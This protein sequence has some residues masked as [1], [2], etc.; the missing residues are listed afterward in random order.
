MLLRFGLTMALIGAVMGAPGAPAM[1]ADAQPSPSLP[2]HVPVTD[3][4]ASGAPRTLDTPRDFPVLH[5]KE[6]WEARRAAIRRQLLV[7]FGLY[8]LPPKPVLHA[9]VFGRIER[10]GYTIEKAYFQTYP[11]FYLAGNLYRPRAGAN[12]SSD[13]DKNLRKP[14]VLIAHGHWQE[15]RMA[16]QPDGSIPARA[17]TFARQ[18]YVAFTYDMVG[19]NDTRQFDHKFAGDRRHWLWSISLMGLQTW[20]SMCAVDFLLSLPD[21]DKSRISITGESGGGTQT[22]M[23]GALDDR[24]AAVGP[25]VMVSHT[26]QGGC[27]CENAPGL[28]IDYSNMEIAAAA[29]PKPQIMVG[30]SGDWTRTM[31]TVEGPS[32]ASV[33]KL[34]NAEDNLKYVRFDYGHNINQTSREAVYAFFGKTLL[35]ETDEAKLK[36]PAYKMEPVEALRVFPDGAPLPTDAKSADAFTED[37]IAQ[38]RADLEKRKPTDRRSLAEFKK[39][40]RS[41]WEHTLAIDIPAKDQLMAATFLPEAVEGGTRTRMLL[42]RAGRGDSIPAILFL[43]EVASA[44]DRAQAIVLVHP[45]G[46]SHWLDEGRNP[47]PVVAALLKRGRAVFLPDAFLTGERADPDVEKARKPFDN[48]FAT[49]NR[50]DLQERV[51]DLITACDYLRSRR[52][53]RSVSL[54]GAGKAGLWTLL[55]APEADAVAADC[56]QFDLTNDAG[57]LADDLFVP[58]LRRMG[59]FATSVVLAAPHPALLFNTGSSF[60]AT[61]RIADA[62]KNIDAVQALSISRGDMEIADVTEWVIEHGK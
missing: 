5:T 13:R 10:D 29:A 32:V 25:C 21:V 8:P 48:Y 27:L 51:Q 52:E 20:N 56:T 59:D 23:L 57:L 45:E 37:R 33:Y 24:L 62:Y 30:A 17:I 47:G 61:D 54:V 6:E 1:P 12:A 55:A 11:G 46:K 18:G 40:F 19:F 44:S 53:I 43:P 34:L 22:M 28:R 15:G 41:A 35:S 7:S 58:G 3:L 14:A 36:E 16:D 38:A 42:G 26:M 50:T 60:T 9:K 4:R 31:M 49:Y 2:G 39:A